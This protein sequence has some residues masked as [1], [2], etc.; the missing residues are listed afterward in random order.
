MKVTILNTRNG[1]PDVHKTGCADIKRGLK[2]GKY[3]ADEAQDA[4]VASILEATVA[5]WD[6]GILD[7]QYG[8]E[9]AP[10]AT[11]LDAANGHTAY[12]NF[13]PCTA[14]LE[15][16]DEITV[17]ELSE[18]PSETAAD[19]VSSTQ[20]E[21]TEEGEKMAI[22]VLSEGMGKPNI[23]TTPTPD[24]KPTP[25]RRSRKAIAKTTG[26]K[27][28]TKTQPKAKTEP[29]TDPQPKAEKVQA[30][31]LTKKRE[32]AT[33]VVLAAAQIPGLTDE[34]KLTV[35]KWLHHL[36]ADRTEWLKVLPNPGRSDWK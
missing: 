6:N 7:E 32:L 1:D 3:Y 11:K 31:K 10:Y 29:K 25:P 15:F 17:K 22:S 12:M 26:T 30:E 35:S 21:N 24:T 4:N 18:T 14:G 33:K 27:G 9:G 28:T 5:Y 23:E 2:T 20:E 16:S 36:P 8:Y 19:A 34:E 13:L